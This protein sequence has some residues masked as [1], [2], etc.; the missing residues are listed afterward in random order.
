MLFDVRPAT[1][2]LTDIQKQI[3]VSSA[4]HFRG[5][6]A[7]PGT[8][9]SYWLKGDAGNVR[10]DISD[11]TGRVVRT[12]DGTKTAGL[13]RVRWNLQG[14]PPRGRGAAAPGSGQAEQPAATAPRRSRRRPI[15][16]PT[17]R[18]R[19]SRGPAVKI[20]RRRRHRRATGPAGAAPAS[21]HN[22][23]ACRCRRAGRRWWRRPRPRRLRR[24][25]ARRHLS[26]QADGGRQSHRTEDGRNRSGQSAV[27]TESGSPI[28]IRYEPEETSLRIETR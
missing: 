6:N 25:A 15:L 20:G 7:D 16:R 24:R 23:G 13:N 11:V 1:S 10:V 22:G 21:R 17:L 8:A 28:D 4:K 2:W 9:I 12:I 26:R 5:Q 14:N 19:A 18:P 3:T 27:S